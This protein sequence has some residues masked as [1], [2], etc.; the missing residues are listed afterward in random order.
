ML[1]VTEQRQIVRNRALWR[2]L[3]FALLALLAGAYL[4]VGHALASSGGASAAP[5]GGKVSN[6]A[7]QPGQ[8]K[9]ANPD[10]CAANYV[11][12]QSEGATPVAGTTLVTG[13]Q[14]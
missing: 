2:Y 13:S 10:D 11:V 12:V 4:M 8:S 1:E 9:R 14:W 3:L 7:V 6:S 5:Q